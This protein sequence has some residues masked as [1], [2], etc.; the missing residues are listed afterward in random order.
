MVSN[1]VEERPVMTIP[2]VADYLR[3]STWSAYELARTG[4]LPVLHLG[5]R[6]VVSRAAVERMLNQAGGAGGDA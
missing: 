1:D 3:I 6:I 4:D 5:R 2:E